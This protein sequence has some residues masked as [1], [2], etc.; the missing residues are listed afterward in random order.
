[1]GAA[2]TSLGNLNASVVL[3][4]LMHRSN[5]LRKK[6]DTNLAI[7]VGIEKEREDATGTLH[8][9]LKRFRKT[10]DYNYMDNG[11]TEARKLPGL[12]LQSWCGRWC[13]KSVSPAILTR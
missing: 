8:L 6:F 3:L 11:S 10:L 4:S 1:M 9:H 2:P 7:A 5:C 12:L 13:C